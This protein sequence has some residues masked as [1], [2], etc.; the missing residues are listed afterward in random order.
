[1]SYAPIKYRIIRK[2]HDGHER[3]IRENLIL[4]EVNKFHNDPTNHLTRAGRRWRGLQ[5]WRHYHEVDNGV[6][7]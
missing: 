4:E 5:K 2:F 6:K 1:M 7:E 3:I